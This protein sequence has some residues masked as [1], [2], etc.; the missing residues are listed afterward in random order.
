MQNE[1]TLH[2]SMRLNDIQVVNLLQ[3]QILRPAR[4]EVG[5]DCDGEGGAT[6]RL[7]ISTI[8]IDYSIFEKCM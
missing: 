6:Y 2:I 7:Q 4:L 1:I 8:Q 5:L 3:T